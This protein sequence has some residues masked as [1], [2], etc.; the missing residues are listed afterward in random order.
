MSNPPVF[1][2]EIYLIKLRPPCPLASLPD[3]KQ[4]LQRKVSPGSTLFVNGTHE[5]VEN[6]GK[7]GAKP[8]YTGSHQMLLEGH[9]QEYASLK[10]KN[11]NQFWSM[12]FAEW[13]R[14]FPWKL[15]D[16]EEP[17][18][19]DP[20]AMSQLASVQAGE[21]DRK[22][23]VEAATVSVSLPLLSAMDTQAHCVDVAADQ[24]LVCLP[25]PEPG[26][27]QGRRLVPP[28]STPPRRR[29]PQA[30]QAL[31]GSTIYTGRTLPHRRGVYRQV[32]ERLWHGRS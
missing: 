25:N 3:H 4:C 13:W 8:Y 1:L 30:T 28:P 29:A 20:A 15:D 17:P 10:H 11:H 18:L 26:P 32:R 6:P 24:T 5:G 16:K 21:R 31:P 19:D 2:T 14:N 9:L 27:T 22:S 12:V 23:E 7:R